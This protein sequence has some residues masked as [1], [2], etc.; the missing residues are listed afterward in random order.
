M[1]HSPMSHKVMKMQNE[2]SKL[3]F[4]KVEML[5][6]HAIEFLYQSQLTKFCSVNLQ[7]ALIDLAGQ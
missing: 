7:V 5:A 2:K 4:V 3:R 1:I 6:L